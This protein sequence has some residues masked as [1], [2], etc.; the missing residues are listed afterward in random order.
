MI[1]AIIGDIVGSVYE[2]RSIK[3]KEFPLFDEECRL[4]DDS[5]MT[6][7]VA[8]ALIK[9]KKEDS[10]L[11]KEVV[12]EMLEWGRKYPFAGYGGNFVLWLTEDNPKPYNS[13]GNGSA[14]RVSACGF[15][16]KSLDEA[17][18]WAESSARV[19]HN[20]Y[21]GIKGAKATAAAIFF[22]KSGKSKEYI[23]DYIEKEFYVLSES[24]D[25]IRKYYEFDVTCQG[26]VPPAL[27]CFLESESFEDA[28]RNAISLGG[29]SD[30]LACITG[31]IAEAFYGVPDELK[32]KAYRYFDD[33]VARAVNEIEQYI[34]AEKE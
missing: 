33:D 26:T 24:V 25:E 17:L 34:V 2:F 16:A 14:M 21:E 13:Y 29:D 15:Y 22:A 27:Q 8:K 11:E 5:I 7:A 3:T 32:M 6:I 23:K 19:S 20:H 31:G 1:G 10:D 12:K 9:T 18:D 4:T 28:I 30:T